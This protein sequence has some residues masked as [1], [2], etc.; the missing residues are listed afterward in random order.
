MSRIENPAVQRASRGWTPKRM[1]YGSSV[2]FGS[3]ATIIAGKIPM[4]ASSHRLLE[5]AGIAGTQ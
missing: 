2:D 5:L 4:C 3:E 1:I